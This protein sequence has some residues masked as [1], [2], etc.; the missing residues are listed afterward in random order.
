MK[1]FGRE[2]SGSAQRALCLAALLALSLTA[3]VSAREVT[4]TGKRCP[5][6]FTPA[7]EAQEAS[8]KKVKSLSVLGVLDETQAAVIIGEERGFVPVQELQEKL[9]L[10]DLAVLP[11][12]SEWTDLGINSSGDRVRE[13]QQ[14]LINLTYLTG[15]ADGAYGNMTAQALSDFQTAEGLEATGTADLFT[16]LILADA[17]TGR[18]EAFTTEYP[19]EIKPEDKFGLILSKVEDASALE[20]YLTPEWSFSYDVIEKEGRITRG[21]TV[22]SYSKQDRDVDRLSMTAQEQVYVFENAGGSVQVVPALLLTSSGAYRPCVESVL[23]IAGDEVTEYPVLKTS[24]A[25]EGIQVQ[26]TDYVQ[27]GE[28]GFA[29]LDREDLQ[30]R[31][32]GK[33]ADYDLTR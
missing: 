11:H 32:K 23:L 13:L 18:L 5:L 1:R 20:P 17:G 27:L 19:T 31:V 4:I 7:G 8:V 25:L 6:T 3:A 16:Y 14:H 12:V 10:L 9:P 21:R 22:G 29:L 28:E 30:I 15:A 33:N 26:E 2:K 24:R